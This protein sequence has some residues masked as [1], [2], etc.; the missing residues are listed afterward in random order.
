MRACA[1]LAAQFDAYD[2]DGSGTIDLQEFG[3]V[4]RAL[5]Q[6]L[7]ARDLQSLLATADTSGDGRLDFDEFY[8][9]LAVNVQEN[10][11][12]AAEVRRRR[13]EDKLINLGTMLSLLAHPVLSS[14]ILQVASPNSLAM[15][16]SA[17]CLWSSRT[18]HC[19]A[20]SR[21]Q[22]LQCV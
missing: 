14:R 13:V 18:L 11:E 7:A 16:I 10:S 22:L 5:G 19:K 2:K 8:Q 3:D 1:V 9:L 6:H 17:S 20:A 21:A 15:W 12:R 4:M